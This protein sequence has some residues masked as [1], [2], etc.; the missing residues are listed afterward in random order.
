MRVKPRVLGSS[1]LDKAAKILKEI[2]KIIKK[3][4]IPLKIESRFLAFQYASYTYNETNFG[5]RFIR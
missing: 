1:F 5:P 4:S 3:P 2:I